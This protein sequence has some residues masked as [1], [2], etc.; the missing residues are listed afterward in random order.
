MKLTNYLDQRG[1]R[2]VSGLIYAVG[3]FGTIDGD[4]MYALKIE[5]DEQIYKY[6][7]EKVRLTAHFVEYENGVI[8]RKDTFENLSNAPMQVRLLSSRFRLPGNKY[9][10]YT[11]YNGWQHESLGEWQ[12]LVTQVATAGQGIRSCHTATPMMAL[13][14]VYTKKNVVFHLFPNGLWKI[15]ARKFPQDKNEVVVVETGFDNNGM[16]L[17]VEPNGKIELPTILFYDADNK[18]DLDAYKLHQVYNELYPRKTLPV[19]Y[20]TWLHCF[21]ALD[22]DDLKRQADTAKELGIE[23]FMVDAGWFGHG[24]WGEGVGDWT[25]NL[26]EG[27][28]GRLAELSKH[29]RDNGMVFGLWFEPERAGLESHA[30]KEHPEYFINGRFFNFANEEARTHMIDVIGSQIEKY[31]IGW[32]KF[33]FNDSIPLDESG[34]VFYYYMQGQRQFVEDLRARYPHVYITNCA[35]GGSRMELEQGSFTDSFWLSDNQGP[36][37]GIRIVKDTLKRM[38]TGLIERWNVQKGL[39]NTPVYGQKLKPRM[40][41][42]NDGLWTT[43][44]GVNDCFSENFMLGGPMGFSCDINAFPEEYKTRWKEVIAQY[45]QDREFYRTATARILIDDPEMIGLEYADKNLDRCVIQIF[46]KQSYASDLIIYPVVD[47][48]ATYSYQGTKLTGEEILKDGLYI[49]D[50]TDYACVCLEIRKV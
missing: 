6:E 23:A 26:L 15:S 34:N 35:G 48:A 28:K 24:N 1:V 7:D 5:N 19:L 25:E 36:L 49:K 21:D 9:D 40:I 41:H 2:S 8:I 33:D 27:P 37:E 30:V 16:N 44:V 45:K 3:S 39:E 29:I 13:H 12:P 47:K 42:T 38:P 46:T 18:I 4:T 31:Q 17:S 11:Q 50:M 22:I 10:V 43:I 32:L 20:N 14:N